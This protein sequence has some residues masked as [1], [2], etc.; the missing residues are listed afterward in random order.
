MQTQVLTSAL[1]QLPPVGHS[2]PPLFR[3]HR[4]EVPQHAGYLL[5]RLGRDDVFFLVFQKKK[6]VG[7]MCHS[8]FFDPFHP[9]FDFD[10]DLMIDLLLI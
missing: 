10:F 9:F 3:G 7:K 2:S 5:L 6:R 1:D 4:R 8:V